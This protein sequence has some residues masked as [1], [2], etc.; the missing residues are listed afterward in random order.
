MPLTA[1]IFLVLYFTGLIMT[2]RYPYIGIATYIFLWHNHPPYMWWGDPLP[3]LRWSLVISVVTLISLII[4]YNGLPSLRKSNYTLIW[5]LVA[6]T[7]WMYFVSAFCA[8]DPVESYRKA[9]TFCKFTVQA[10]LMMFL[11]RTIKQYKFVI[12]TFILNVANFGKIAYERGSNRYL[13]VMA[14]NSGEENAIAAHVTAMIPFFGLYFLTGKKWVKIIT[15]VSLPFL[16]NLIILSNSRA[17]FLTLA[18]LGILTFF[19]IRGRLRW[20]VLL[21]LFAGALLVLFLANDTFWERQKTMT[22]H[23]DEGASGSR[24]LLWRGALEMSADHPLG[25]G[26]EGFEALV[27]SYVPELTETMEEAGAKAVHNTF[28][29]VLVEWGY[30]GLILFTGF[31]IHT[32]LILK[33]IRRDG[34]RAAKYLCCHIDAVS[35]QLGLIGIL[36]AGLFHSR[37]YSEVFYWFAAFAVALRN[38]QVNEIAEEIEDTATVGTTASI[39]GPYEDYRPEVVYE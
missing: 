19:W 3:D 9:E 4:N 1:C 34:K 24:F 35:I 11:L 33:K 15:M 27:F 8:V 18:I 12:W 32:F 14:P 16:L 22:E 26:G 20:R 17:S 39:H 5:W 30:V 6:L 37:L 13:G 21:A 23:Q 10:F 36:V 7:I 29:T 25:V 31:L 2:F 38:I 28:L